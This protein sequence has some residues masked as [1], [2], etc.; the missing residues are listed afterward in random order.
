[1][2]GLLAVMLVGSAMV[3]TA[4][5]EPGPF[6][7]HRAIG[8][9][10]VGEKIEPKAPENFSGT[11]GK[12]TLTGTVSGVA[13]EIVSPSAQI[14]GA[15]FNGPHQGQL[16]VEIIYSQPQLVKPALSECIPTINT[17]NIAVVK[18]HLAWKWNGSQSQLEEQPQL[19]QKPDIIFTNVEPQRQE[20]FKVLDYRTVGTFATISLSG[21]CGVLGGLG[22]LPVSGSE[23]ALP[24]KPGLEE[25]STELGIRT[26]PSGTLSGTIG[27]EEKFEKEG[28]LQHIWVG[29]GTK[30]ATE[31]F[32]GIVAGL[33]FASNPANLVGQ[34]TA[35]SA[36]QEVAVFEK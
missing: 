20:P 9:K 12:Q 19:N 4:S 15:I 24:N 8:G 21:K 11:G 34:F 29:G 32:Q 22:A 18:G 13:I 5:A 31:G 23:V 26:I 1:M 35:T 25:W 27:K 7:H 6:W 33:T 2:L 16:K 3:A 14:K 10:G 30:E 17:N 36:Q 28:F